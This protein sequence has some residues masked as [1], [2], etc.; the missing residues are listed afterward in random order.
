MSSTVYKSGY[1]NKNGANKRM[2]ISDF[3]QEEA[4]MSAHE[5]HAHSRRSLHKTAPDRYGMTSGDLHGIKCG[6]G[7]EVRQ[8]VHIPA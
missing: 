4:T 6:E 8:D 3:E 5:T 1:K 7:S 2:R